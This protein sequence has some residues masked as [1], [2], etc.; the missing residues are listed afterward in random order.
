MSWVPSLAAGAVKVPSLEIEPAEADQVTAVLLVSAT[1]AANRCFAV[2]PRVV[3]EGETTTRTCNS[4]GRALCAKL[5]APQPTA[6]I[7]T[8]PLSTS[9]AMRRRVA[10][11]RGCERDKLGDTRRK[12]NG[13]TS[14][15][16]IWGT[17]SS[18]PVLTSHL[19]EIELVRIDNK[20]SW[21]AM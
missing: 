16:T 21:P 2:G 17:Y 14:I 13:L 18:G 6:R 5:F 20:R 1:V 15:W 10:A 11:N 9:V 4:A 19:S 12:I 7:K 3:V 8:S